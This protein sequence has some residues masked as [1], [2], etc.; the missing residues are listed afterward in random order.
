M[1]PN[2]LEGGGISSPV[3]AVTIVSTAM[4]NSIFEEDDEE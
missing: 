2:S 3:V 1:I 4:T